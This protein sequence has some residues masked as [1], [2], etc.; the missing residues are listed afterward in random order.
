[1]RQFA[2]LA[3]AG[4][5]PTDERSPRGAGSQDPLDLQA[6]N[7]SNDTAQASPSKDL[8]E[9]QQSDNV[10]IVA[11]VSNGIS[12]TPSEHLVT[13]ATG[14]DAA[15]GF[16]TSQIDDPAPSATG[17][18]HG[19][20]AGGASID[21]A[22][23]ADSDGVVNVTTSEGGV[24]ARDVSDDTPSLGEGASSWHG[25]DTAPLDAAPLADSDGL[26]HLS[27][28]DGP[29]W[30]NDTDGNL[31]SV[32]GSVRVDGSVSSDVADI[33]YNKDLG[34]F[35]VG[36]SGTVVADLAAASSSHAD[37]LRVFW[38]DEIGRRQHHFHRL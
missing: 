14:L 19:Q 21:V 33:A 5:D 24:L 18:S 28:N 34:S 16:P 13:A 11:D 1:M 26:T 35:N 4:I 27:A 30:F 10:L 8:T 37:A 36:S 29:I 38:R 20:A 3:K 7:F 32:D 17:A 31:Q 15:F 23:L 9:Q 12:Q 2:D 22:P 25:H 6:T